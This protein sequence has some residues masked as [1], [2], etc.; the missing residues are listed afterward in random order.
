MRH[1]L[2][3]VCA[4]ALAAM[5]ATA[6]SGTGPTG[7]GYPVGSFDSVRSAGP[8]KVIVTTGGAASVRAEG[9]AETLD[10][11]EVV[12]EGGDLQ[13]RPREAYRR[14]GWRDMKA[15]TFYV[16]AP[17]LKGASVAGSGDMTVNR[18]EGDRFSGSVAGSG[19]LDIASLRVSEANFS[20]AG[21]GDLSARGSTENSRV[22]VA[23]SGNAR[24]QNVATRTASVSVVGSGVTAIRADDRVNVSIV[25]SGDVAVIGKATCSVS[26]MG[27]G[28]VRCGS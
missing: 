26:R 1:G 22:S 2:T 21:S 14:T 4:T 5:A 19:N 9:P 28:Q 20:I 13:I 11:M 3:F 7:R 6:Q 8:H 27:S 12:V 24:L 16:S 10:K 15:A 23:G 18:I 25:G 17:M